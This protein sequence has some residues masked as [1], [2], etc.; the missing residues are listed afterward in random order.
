MDKFVE[1]QEIGLKLQKCLY[2]AKMGV[3]K[4]QQHRQADHAH[5]HTLHLNPFL[6]QKNPAVA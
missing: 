2:T 1:L 5:C 6:I 4:I 3:S